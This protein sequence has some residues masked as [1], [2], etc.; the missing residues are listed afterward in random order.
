MIEQLSDLLGYQDRGGFIENQD[1][2]TPIEHF[3]DFDSLPI[4]HTEISDQLVRIHMQAVIGGNLTDLRTRSITNAVELLG[5]EYHVLKHGEVVCKHEVLEDHADSGLDGI[6]R[7]LEV[8]LFALNGD[9]AFIGGLHTVEDLHQSGFA[10]TVLA[11]DGVDAAAAHIQRDVT[12]GHDTGE[13]FGDPGQLYG[14]RDGGRSCRPA[15]FGGT[16]HGS[17]S[18]HPRKIGLIARSPRH[19]S[20]KHRPGRHFGA[21][22]PTILDYR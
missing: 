15:R 1:A 10:G 14:P 3:E 5:A 22:G 12:V 13:S 7:A 6:G 19:S 4:A 11:D 9:G 18:L 8:D 21:P 17:Y 2:R 16:R 20:G